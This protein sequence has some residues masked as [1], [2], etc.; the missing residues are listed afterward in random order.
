MI[1]EILF[2]Q[3]P[4]WGLGFG[5]GF[6]LLVLVEGNCKRFALPASA[7]PSLREGSGTPKSSVGKVRI[8]GLR[9]GLASLGCAAWRRSEGLG[10]V[11]PIDAMR[12]TRL[13]VGEGLRLGPGQGGLGWALLGRVA[14][15]AGLKPVLGGLG[16]GLLARVAGWAGPEAGSRQVRQAGLAWLGWA[17]GQSQTHQTGLEASLGQLEASLRRAG[18]PH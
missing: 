10:H 18:Q 13:L 16:C 4:P 6:E 5:C 1:S 17:T 8:G 2:I 9:L 15:W 14:G 11:G 3:L 12:R 7:Q